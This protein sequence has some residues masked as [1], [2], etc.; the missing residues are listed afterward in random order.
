MSQVRVYVDV[1]DVFSQ[2]NDAELIA[3]MESRGYRCAKHAPLITLEGIDHIE[4]LVLCGMY[5]DARH[6]A[7]VMLEKQI[8]R[9]NTLTAH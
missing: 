5:A 7:L 3:E 2:V 4:H 1:D 6:E 9:P 8:Q